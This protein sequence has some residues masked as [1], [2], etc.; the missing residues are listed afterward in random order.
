MRS[1]VHITFGIC[2]LVTLLS[3]CTTVLSGRPKG[4]D[5]TGIR[6]SLPAPHVFLNPQ[7]D[8][9]V[10]VEVKYLA[11]PTNTYSLNLKS[12]LS[13]ATFNVSL[14]DGMLTQ[15]SLNSDATAVPAGVATAATALQNARITAD[16]NEKEAKKAKIEADK[17]VATAAANAVR[18]QK[19]KIAQLEGKLAFALSNAGTMTQEEVLNIKA[20]INHEKLVLTQLESRLVSA[21]GSPAANQPLSAFMD[22]NATDAGLLEA[23]GPVLFRVLTDDT[24]AG[25][26][27]VSVENQR[28]FETAASAATPQTA[29]I[30]VSPEKIIIKTGDKD[31]KIRFS[32]SSPTEITSIGLV[33]PAA[34][35][36][37]ILSGDQLK[38]THDENN[39][40][41]LEVS[42]PDTLP[43]GI[44]RLDV[45][46]K[47][48]AGKQQESIEISWLID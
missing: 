16:Q 23:Y 28:T 26:K 43:K 27:L 5:P 45:T 12:Y 33:L 11:D 8:G 13:K 21:G 39:P 19:E 4:K 31:R 29:P 18:E 17:Q 20:E 22:P 3:G 6:Y 1:G 48:T 47:V 25:V 24:G 32:L 37:N 14:K 15:V 36:A 30:Q 44:Y 42:L 9:T 7:P 10:I 34:G 41:Q 35:T 40:L 46:L 38:L 2:A